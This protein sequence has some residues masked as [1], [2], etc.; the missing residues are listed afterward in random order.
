MS[1]FWKRKQN[2]FELIQYSNTEEGKVYMGEK[3]KEELF[4]IFNHFNKHQNFGHKAYLNLCKHYKYYLGKQESTC[5][6]KNV[7]SA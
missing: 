7:R 3:D 1:D 6:E 5:T 2:L 4:E